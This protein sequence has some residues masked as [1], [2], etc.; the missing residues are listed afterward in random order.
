MA[1]QSAGGNVGFYRIQWQFQFNYA[2]L[3]LSIT[4]VIKEDK[5]IIDLVRN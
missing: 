3:T 2:M 5:V 1:A 4:A